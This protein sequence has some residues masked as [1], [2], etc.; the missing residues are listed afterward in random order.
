MHV[1]QAPQQKSCNKQGRS[2][3]RDVE[4][5]VLGAGGQRVHGIARRLDV[6]LPGDLD[7]ARARARAQAQGSSVGG[8][9]ERGDGVRRGGC[10][11]LGGLPAARG[12][13]AA[14]LGSMQVGRTRTAST[15]T[16]A[17]PRAR[18]RARLPALCGA[19]WTHDA[20]AAAMNR[21]MRSFML[22]GWLQ[23]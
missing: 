20:A 23:G 5:V 8:G 4:L 16:T 10:A 13:R 7:C 14:S 21:A 15:P 1:Q 12:T 17:Q 19:A 6:E 3:D 9:E 2:L 18:A 11:L 22:S